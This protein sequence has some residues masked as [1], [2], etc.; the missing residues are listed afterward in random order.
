MYA[1]ILERAYIVLMLETFLSRGIA[2]QRLNHEAKER[3]P[4][5]KIEFPSYLFTLFNRNSRCSTR[6]NVL[7]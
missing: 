5:G 3:S 1:L 7:M 4:R 6:R 2:F